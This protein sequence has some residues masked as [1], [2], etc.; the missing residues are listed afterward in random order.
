MKDRETG[1]SRGFGF[2][3]RHDFPTLRVCA[4]ILNSTLLSFS[5]RPTVPPRRPTTPSPLWTDRTWTDVRSESTSLTN[6]PV[7][8]VSFHSLVDFPINQICPFSSN[9]S[10]HV[11][12]RWPVR[13]PR[14][15]RI[16]RWPGWLRRPGRIRWWLRRSVWW[17]R[18]P[19]RLL[20]GRLRRSR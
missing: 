1:R 7:E 17:L 2:V 3:V 9:T 5:P 8:V 19:R 10:T 20:A 18:R 11:P 16:R 6:V 15:W 4:I 14:R 13:L 12:R